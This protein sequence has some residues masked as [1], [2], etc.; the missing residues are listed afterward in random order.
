M[1][2]WKIWI[3]GRHGLNLW[4]RRVLSFMLDHPSKSASVQNLFER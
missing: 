4:R 3:G 2:K 1:L